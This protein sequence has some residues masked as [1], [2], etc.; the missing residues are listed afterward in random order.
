MS[1][2]RKKLAV[3]AA[4]VPMVLYSGLGTG[5]AQE[6]PTFDNL[7]HFAAALPHIAPE[8]SGERAILFP[9]D[10]P[11]GSRER[12]IHDRV[13]EMFAP[14]R[15]RRTA[16]FYERF[17]EGSLRAEVVSSLVDSARFLQTVQ[18]IRFLEIEVWE[19]QGFSPEAYAE[20]SIFGEPNMKAVIVYLS[21]IG[22]SWMI[23]DLVISGLESE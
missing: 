1:V 11:A 12:E 15:E 10:L 22:D 16:E 19:D 6:P 14:F 21:Y 20:L 18:E 8:H 17:V 7:L 4:A 23:T 5:A 13:R 3:L 2:M 9:G